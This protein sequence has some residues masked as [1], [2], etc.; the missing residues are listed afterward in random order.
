MKPFYKNL[1]LLRTML[2]QHKSYA[3]FA[4]DI[5]REFVRCT[6]RIQGKDYASRVFPQSSFILIMFPWGL[7]DL[8]DNLWV[9]LHNEWRNFLEREAITS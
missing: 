1:V 5:I 3:Y 6:Q 2:L 4:A 8:S 7:S 9:D